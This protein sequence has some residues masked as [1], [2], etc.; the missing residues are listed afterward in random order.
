MAGPV[1]WRPGSPSRGEREDSRSCGSR[2]RCRAA[3]QPSENGELSVGALQEDSR[4]RHPPHVRRRDHDHHQHQDRPQ[5]PPRPVTVN[6]DALSGA[7]DATFCFICFLSLVN[8]AEEGRF[9]MALLCDDSERVL[10]SWRPLCERAA[11]AGGEDEPR[12]ERHGWLGCRRRRSL[13]TTCFRPTRKVVNARKGP[14]LL[15]LLL[16]LYR[17]MNRERTNYRGQVSLFCCCRRCPCLEGSKV[18]RG[19]RCNVSA[20]T[21]LNV[22]RWSFE[23]EMRDLRYSVARTFTMWIR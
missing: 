20:L 23:K 7:R 3:S 17:R 14:P 11:F 16:L 4:S 15:L 6:H 18:T 13:V 10:Q 21:L 8:R 12:M 1:R 22:A 2:Q 19:W 9:V 5:L